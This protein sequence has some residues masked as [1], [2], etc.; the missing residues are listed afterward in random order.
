MWDVLGNIDKAL[1]KFDFDTTA[2]TQRTICWYVKDSCTNVQENK[3]TQMDK[4]ISG[5]SG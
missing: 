3:G 4:I 1:L 5:L 2:C